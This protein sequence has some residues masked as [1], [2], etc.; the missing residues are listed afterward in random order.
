MQYRFSPILID[1]TGVFI[2]K[3]DLLSRFR[4]ILSAAPLNYGQYVINVAKLMP[5]W[6][7]RL[8]SAKRSGALILQSHSLFDSKF[9][10]A[11][12]TFPD[13]VLELFVTITKLT[14]TGLCEA[15]ILTTKYLNHPKFW[16]SIGTNSSAGTVMT[17]DPSMRF[18]LHTTFVRFV[19][20][21]V[22]PTCFLV[23]LVVVRQH[24]P[25]VI[26]FFTTGIFSIS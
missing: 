5:F 6:N 2:Y 21:Q 22:S 14:N 17:V 26:R 12:Q 10:W 4:F 8:Q 1:K 18:L 19:C 25:A 24:L 9:S 15:M 11:M 16:C 7:K 3:G 20:K 13:S 23:L